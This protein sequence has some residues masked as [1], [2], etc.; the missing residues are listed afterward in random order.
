MLETAK[1]SN[2]SGQNEKPNLA[3]DEKCNDTIRDFHISHIL[4][5][6]PLFLSPFFPF[7]SFF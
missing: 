6:S 5:L 3:V 1:R 4:N 7:F 2:K